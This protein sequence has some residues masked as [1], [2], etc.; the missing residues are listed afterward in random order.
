VSE[1]FEKFSPGWFVAVHATI[2]LV[3][4]LR[5]AVVMPKAAIVGTIAAAV[6]G[7]AVGARLERARLAHEAAHGPLLVAPPALAEAWQQV[8]R[9]CAA[10]PAAAA[11]VAAA[12]AT[13][14]LAAALAAV[15]AAGV[16]SDG[17]AGGPQEVPAASSMQ[18]GVRCQQQRGG[19]RERAGRAAPVRGPGVASGGGAS[20]PASCG[21]SSGVGRVP[22]LLAHLP[23]VRA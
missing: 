6:I 7:Q 14:G 11:A 9:A 1:H 10:S 13:A 5:K 4:M 8:E 21:S 19:S 17:S 22:S 18:A 23:L 3:A 16:S 2:P 20:L 15:G 12:A